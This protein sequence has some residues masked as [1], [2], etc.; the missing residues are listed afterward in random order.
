MNKFY[1]A[2]ANIFIYKES[3]KLH[4]VTSYNGKL[5]SSNTHKIRP[6]FGKA[7][8]LLARSAG[9]LEEEKALLTTECPNATRYIARD[10]IPL[11]DW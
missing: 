7:C 11:T 8:L 6:C 1:C 5:K 10:V 2:Y 9:S 4:G 3:T